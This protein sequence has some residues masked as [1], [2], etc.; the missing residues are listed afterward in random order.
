MAIYGYARVST[1]DQNLE[2]Q[3]V[4]LEDAKV[5]YI[6]KDKITGT[7]KD[8][9]E[10]KLLLETIKEGDTII[11][12]DLT[13]ISR[14]SKDLFELVE[15][16]KLKGANLKSIKDTWLDTSAENPYSEFLLRIMAAVNQLERDLIY[17]RT[18]EGV[19]I[20]KSKGKYK[21]RIPK[22]HDKNEKLL[23]AL[24][25]YEMGDK[26]VKQIC[27]ITGVGRSTLYEK[28]KEKGVS[29]C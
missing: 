25:L 26:T 23:H 27:D 16:I 4:A 3:I 28:I 12:T 14:S 17:E 21:G 15:I 19:A 29:R 6:F 1:L 13:R 9:P 7:K 8:R 5:S 24:E 11:V 22:Y 20:A 18:K 10:L 2:R